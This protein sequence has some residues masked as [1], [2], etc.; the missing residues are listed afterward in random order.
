MVA[1]IVTSKVHVQH[2][3][4]VPFLHGEGLVH[5]PRRRGELHDVRAV[6]PPEL[7]VSGAVDVPARVRRPLPPE[8]HEPAEIRN[9]SQSPTDA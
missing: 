1:A 2:E 4:G 9:T 7:E 8:I 5:L 3:R 6:V